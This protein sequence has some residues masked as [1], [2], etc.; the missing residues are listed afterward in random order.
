MASLMRFPELGFYTLPGR[1][2]DPFGATMSAL[3]G[4]RFALGFG[5]GFDLRFDCGPP[6]G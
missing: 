1:V 3:S 5:R 4:G 2:A 6:R